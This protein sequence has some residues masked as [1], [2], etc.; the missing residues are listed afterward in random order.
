[1]FVAI[2]LLTTFVEQ[3]ETQNESDIFLWVIFRCRQC[4]VRDI[5]NV[6]LLVHSFHGNVSHEWLEGQS[7]KGRNE[8][9]TLQFLK[10][11]PDVS[12]ER[13]NRCQSITDALWVRRRPPVALRE[14]LGGSETHGSVRLDPD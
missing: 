1:M 4:S 11:P 13:L 6:D 12:N 8:L 3:D 14:Q 10:R 9:R 2:K 7:I 5:E